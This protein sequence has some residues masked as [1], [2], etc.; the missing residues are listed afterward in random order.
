MTIIVFLIILLIGSLW[1][2]QFVSADK[3]LNKW[4]SENEFTLLSREL[5]F[6]RTGPYFV[7]KNRPIFFVKIKNKEGKVDTYWIE[8][9]QLGNYVTALPDI[10]SKYLPLS[11]RL[12]DYGFL[13]IIWIGLFYMLFRAFL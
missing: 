11:V 12:L 2:W 7:F 5:R 4:A 10:E 9:G 13:V 1:I 3:Y 6:F 8:L